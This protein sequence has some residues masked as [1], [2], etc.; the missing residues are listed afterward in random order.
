MREEF[1]DHLWGG[2]QIWENHE[3]LPCLYRTG[4]YTA[5]KRQGKFRF[6]VKKRDQRI[7]HAMELL[8]LDVF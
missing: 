4:D 5:E 2:D 8:K 1:F 3:H 6:A 7:G